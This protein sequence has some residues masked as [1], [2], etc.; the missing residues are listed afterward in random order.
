MSEE[1]EIVNSS[2]IFKDNDFLDNQQEKT[3]AD[4]STGPREKYQGTKI[5]QYSEDMLDSVSGDSST[6]DIGM[7]EEELNEFEQWFLNFKEYSVG[8]L[9]TGNVTNILNNTVYVDISYKAEGIIE[10]DELSFIPNTKAKD[11]MDI[12][13]EVHVQIIRLENKEGNPVLSKKRADYVLA[14]EK[15]S[16]AA[17]NKES[18][19]VFILGRMNDGLLATFDGIRCYIPPTQLIP[20]TKN[21]LDKAK[22]STIEVRVLKAD[23]RRK[24]VILSE[25]AIAGEQR[26]EASDF[27]ENIN[28]GDKVK[29]T[30]SNIKSY[31]A[32]V[33]IGPTHGLIHISELSWGRVDKVEDVLNIGDE[34]EA[35]VC[36]KDEEKVK[37]SLTLKDEKSDPWEQIRDKY[38]LGD[39]EE[40]VITRTAAF[41]AF[42]ELVPGVEGLIHISEFSDQRVQKVTD[43]VKPGEK[44]KAMIIRLNQDTKKIAFS[45]RSAQQKDEELKSEDNSDINQLSNA[46]N[47]HSVELNNEE[48]VTE[49]NEPVS[50]QVNKETE[51]PTSISEK[52]SET[53]EVKETESVN[54]K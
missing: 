1:R 47:V 5:G 54:N 41:G 7:A 36:G 3:D 23:R 43:V 28:I 16:E 39:I 32:F 12:G 49:S 33:N 35:I 21:N 20:E 15:L 40:L 37:I 46:D 38:K 13:D 4:K 48:N 50:S 6:D 18:I 17:D 2:D 30:V 19:E 11:I 8:E 26:K 14:W 10:P 42:A 29:G 45:I 24:R 44:V 25:K 27:V 34:V 51:G 9:I 22:H 31:G 52:E 53:E